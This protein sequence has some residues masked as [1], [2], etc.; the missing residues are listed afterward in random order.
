MCLCS[1]M[2]SPGTKKKRWLLGAGRD[3]RE[4]R[5][6]KKKKSTNCPR[7]RRILHASLRNKSQTVPTAI[8]IKPND[9]LKKLQVSIWLEI[10]NPW[11]QNLHLNF[12]TIHLLQATCTKIKTKSILHL[13]QEHLL[14][15]H[16]RTTDV[17]MPNNYLSY[18][19]PMALTRHSKCS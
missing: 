3:G 14:E 9:A 15:V 17:T 2:N 13:K 18:A 12:S 6:K 10:H 8:L 11:F 7:V 16:C 4:R 5:E 1:F 19:D